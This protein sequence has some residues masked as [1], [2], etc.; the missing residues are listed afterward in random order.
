MPRTKP[1]RH[2]VEQITPW[3]WDT[4]EGGGWICWTSDGEAHDLDSIHGRIEVESSAVQR[5]AYE[6]IAT[7][8]PGKREPTTA[9]RRAW[10]K[11]GAAADGQPED[12]D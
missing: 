8:H 11:H 10:R 3:Y 6:L 7:T 12:D 5:A 9:E 4:P 1:S 2:H